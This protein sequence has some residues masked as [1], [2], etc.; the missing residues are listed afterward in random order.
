MQYKWQVK[1]N[2]INYSC[3][4]PSR[5]WSWAR[6]IYQ[7]YTLKSLHIFIYKSRKSSENFV[8]NHACAS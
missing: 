8:P 1:F 6:L 3:G 2:S 4:G 7:F 5:S